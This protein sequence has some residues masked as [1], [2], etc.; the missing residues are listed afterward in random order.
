MFRGAIIKLNQND[1]KFTDVLS[2][3]IISDHDLLK[4]GLDDQSFLDQ[5]E[6]APKSMAWLNPFNLYL[7]YIQDGE[8]VHTERNYEIVDSVLFLVDDTGT[9]TSFL[10]ERI[11]EDEYLLTG[12]LFI[13]IYRKSSALTL[14]QPGDLAKDYA[15]AMYNDL[16]TIQVGDTLPFIEYHY[17]LKSIE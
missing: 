14:I 4:Q 16:E 5:D 1:Y 2:S 10:K 3:Q 11:H 15:L 17:I 12:L 7:M 8:D 6:L 9:K 13:D